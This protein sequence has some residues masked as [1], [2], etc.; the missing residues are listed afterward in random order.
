[1]VTPEKIKNREIKQNEKEIKMV[2]Y[3]T[4]V[5]YTKKTL[6][7]ELMNKYKA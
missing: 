3:K 1:M 2:H 5:K 6:V 4:S 7:G